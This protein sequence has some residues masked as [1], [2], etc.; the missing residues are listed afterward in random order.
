MN[1]FFFKRGT[2]NR[3][4]STRSLPNRQL[5][6]GCPGERGLG[7]ERGG[8]GMVLPQAWVRRG[9]RTGCRM[10]QDLLTRRVTPAESYLQCTE[11]GQ[12]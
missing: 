11:T 4:L 8:G 6:T 5:P 9:A 12:G 2:E 1:V 10:V 7:A 3:E